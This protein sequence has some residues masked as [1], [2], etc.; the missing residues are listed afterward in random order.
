[1]C[2]ADEPA[3][4]NK[5]ACIYWRR[6]ENDTECKWVHQGIR[7]TR[8]RG[9]LRLVESSPHQILDPLHAPWQSVKLYQKTFGTSNNDR[10]R[11][12][13]RGTQKKTKA[14]NPTAIHFGEF[15][16]FSFPNTK[17]HITVNQMAESPPQHAVKFCRVMVTTSLFNSGMLK[18]GGSRL[19]VAGK[20]LT[21][22]GFE[23]SWSKPFI[24]SFGSI[25]WIAVQLDQSN[26]AK[27][28][29]ISNHPK[30]GN[31]LRSHQSDQTHQEPRMRKK[32]ACWHYFLMPT[33]LGLRLII[34]TD[35]LSLSWVGHQEKV[36]V[37]RNPMTSLLC[38]TIIIRSL[39]KLIQTKEGLMCTKEVLVS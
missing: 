29:A 16:Y 6:V 25:L 27:S 12:K 38:V 13:L 14:Q 22:A 9:R 23:E 31:I 7:N 34:K 35:S 33:H 18:Q 32:I 37:S 17:Y 19:K 5:W 3:K 39:P 8:G 2:Q 26:S 11:I 36:S 4:T 30:K 21:G 15:Y 28:A 1:M 24:W 10:S 20:Q